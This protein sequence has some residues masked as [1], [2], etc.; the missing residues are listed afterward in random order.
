MPYFKAKHWW[1]KW[2]FEGLDLEMRQH[3]EIEAAAKSIL[4]DDVEDIDDEGTF[5]VHLQMN[6]KH[7]YHV[8]VEAYC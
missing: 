3:K 2:G 5:Y 8:D 7:M 1:Q 6:P 4:V